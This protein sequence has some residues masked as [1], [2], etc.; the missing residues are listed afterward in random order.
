M[1]AHTISVEE[2]GSKLLAG[3]P[4][5]FIDVRTPGEYERLH[6]PAARLVPLVGL[7]PA[8]VASLRKSPEDPVYAICASGARSAMAC[9]KLEAAGVSPVI[10]VDG[11]ITA[12]EAAG[13][14]VERAAPD[15]MSIERQIR[16]IAGLV[17]LSGLL[18]GRFVHPR[19]RWVSG[20]AAGALTIS[21]VTGFC[22]LALLLAKA[23][24]NKKAM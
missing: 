4:L 17:V 18:L 3:T 9:K 6:L 15:G 7:D 5:T 1:S 14:P 13:L 22:G 16:I 24:W 12:W 20:V 11:G 2:L 10:S 8:Q 23:P 19:F 21:G